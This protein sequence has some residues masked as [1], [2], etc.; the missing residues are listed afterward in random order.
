M[1]RTLAG[2]VASAAVLGWA[3]ATPRVRTEYPPTSPAS[4]QADASPSVP[5]AP[6]LRSD[7]P[8]PG[9]ARAAWDEW[10]GLERAVEDTGHAGHGGD[11]SP[12]EHAG[13]AGHA[14]HGT[15]DTSDEHETKKD[16]Q[17]DHGHPP[18]AERPPAKPEHDHA[19]H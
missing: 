14:E 3:C 18:P 9:D 15:T 7:P 16:G 13:H 19:H 11:A 10:P 6:M 8:L 5:I 12:A 4:V 2:F 17:G 1:S